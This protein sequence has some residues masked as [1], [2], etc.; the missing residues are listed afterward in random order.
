MGLRGVEPVAVTC[1]GL[2]SHVTDVLSLDL[3]TMPSIVLL[4]LVPPALHVNPTRGV[5]LDRARLVALREYTRL[6]DSKIRCKRF[7]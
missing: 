7:S 2:L 4:L 1:R 5:L 3:S 6:E